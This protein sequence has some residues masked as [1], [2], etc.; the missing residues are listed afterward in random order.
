VI[1]AIGDIY[2]EKAMLDEMHRLP[3]RRCGEATR[4]G[5]A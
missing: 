2:G 3:Q 4:N 5:L 1:Y